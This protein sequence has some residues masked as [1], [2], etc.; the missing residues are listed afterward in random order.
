[1]SR[2]WGAMAYKRS[3]HRYRCEHNL[4]SSR[5]TILLRV[6]FIRT[7]YTTEIIVEDIAE[8]KEKKEFLMKYAKAKLVTVRCLPNEVFRFGKRCKTCHRYVK[9]TQRSV[10]NTKRVQ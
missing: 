3:A 1:M 8:D 7:Y 10:W 5:E 2:V 6:P 9:I 4:A